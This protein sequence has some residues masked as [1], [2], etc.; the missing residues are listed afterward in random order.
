VLT[1]LRVAEAW[2]YV[3]MKDIAESAR[4]LDKLLAILWTLTR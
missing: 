1:S 2:G 4:L 3:S